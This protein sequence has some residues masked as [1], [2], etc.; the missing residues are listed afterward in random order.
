MI[1]DSTKTFYGTFIAD[2]VLQVLSFVA[3]QQVDK[4]KR[5][6][7]DG[8]ATAKRQGKHLGRPQLQFDNELFVNVY[9][10]WKNGDI[11]GVQAIQQANMKKT[12]F[13]KNVKEYE[14]QL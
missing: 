10:Q 12:S 13:Y 7:A 5:D 1:Q 3:Q 11:T 8:I 6:Q 9:K 2:L 4:S 14:K